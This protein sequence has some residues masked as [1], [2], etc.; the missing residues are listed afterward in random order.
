MLV[1]LGEVII[2]MNI[3]I[4]YMILKLTLLVYYLWKIKDIWRVYETKSQFERPTSGNIQGHVY[5]H[6]HSVVV[7]EEQPFLW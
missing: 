6:W 3:W 1:L 2:A 5:R 7:T 4:I